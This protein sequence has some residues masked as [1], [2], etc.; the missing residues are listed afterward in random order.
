MASPTLGTLIRSSD[1]TYRQIAE[2]AGISKP[3]VGQ[4]AQDAFSQSPAPRTVRGLAIA[5]E[6]PEAT[7]RAAIR[8]TIHGTDSAEAEE[9]ALRFAALPAHQRSVIVSMIDALERA[10]RQ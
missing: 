9:I 10:N 4:L 3:R 2:R 5:L 6:V 8:Q 7:I 1:L